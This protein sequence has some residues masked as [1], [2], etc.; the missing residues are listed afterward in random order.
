MSVSEIRSSFGTLL[1]NLFSL[2]YYHSILLGKARVRWVL[3]I[4]ILSIL[5]SLY[6]T[7][8]VFVPYYPY[9]PSL[10]SKGEE[11]IKEFVPSDMVITI[12]NGVVSTN[13]SEPYYITISESRWSKIFDT[14]GQNTVSQTRILAIDTKGTAEDF[15]RYQSYA[16]LTQNS[17]VYYNEDKIN[18]VPL[19]SVGDMTIDQKSILRYFTDINSEYHITDI[20]AILFYAL[21]LL[22]IPFFFLTFIFVYLYLTFLVYIIARILGVRVGFG[23]I[24]RYTFAISLVPVFLWDTI[25]YIPVFSYYHTALDSVHTMFVLGL[26]YFGLKTFKE[27]E[28]KS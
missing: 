19:R 3:L 28:G 15:E 16:L 22:F 10:R 6:L 5:A 7:F 24:Y 14:E 20:I 12:K 23:N 18:I 4:F 8:S 1:R 11:V 2:S 25:G 9:I 21:P 17:F 13:V 27:K 26:C